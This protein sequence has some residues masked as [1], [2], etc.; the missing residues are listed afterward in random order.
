MTERKS[1]LLTGV[2]FD[3]T[4]EITLSHLCEVCAVEPVLIAELIGEGILEPLDQQADEPR[5]HYTSVRIT[6]TA[7]RLQADLGVN[8]QGAALALELLEQIENLQQ[9]LRR[10]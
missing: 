7:V 4:T 2:V 6:R 8:L 1:D 3:E 10:K 9:Q 5:F